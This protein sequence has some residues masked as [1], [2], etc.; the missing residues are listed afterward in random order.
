M[1]CPTP[2]PPMIARTGRIVHMDDACLTVRFERQS[3]CTACRAAKAC[4]GN[5]PSTELVVARPPGSHYRCGDSVEVG[6]AEDAA[7]RA[8]LAT[9]LVP[10]AGLLLAMLG[11]AAL[12]L[13]EGAIVLASLGGLAAGFLALRRIARRPALQLQ[14]ALLAAHPNL[15]QEIHS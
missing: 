6:V 11:A 12:G 13:A 14:P 10:L 3:A 1:S 7:L 5:T 4:A 15:H 8:T 9:Y 2:L